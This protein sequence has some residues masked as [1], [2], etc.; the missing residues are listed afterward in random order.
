MKLEIGRE[1]ED[2]VNWDCRWCV[3]ARIDVCVCVWILVQTDCHKRDLTG[4]TWRTRQRDMFEPV[5]TLHPYRIQRLPTTLHHAL[6]KSRG[7]SSRALV[8]R[9][10]PISYYAP[11]SGVNVPF[12]LRSR[13]T[14]A[15]RAL[16]YA[17]SSLSYAVLSADAT[18]QL[19]VH[20][21]ALERY[22]WAQ[23]FIR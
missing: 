16:V 13:V 3:R 22:T 21:I 23:V 8:L 15:F 14:T 18:F 17:P 6:W 5:T 1:A 4:F 11:P 10:A 20:F 19:S 12:Q 7:F 2:W 9:D